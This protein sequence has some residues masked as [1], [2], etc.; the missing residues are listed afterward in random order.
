MNSV[1]QTA[2]RHK[3][4][5]SFKSDNISDKLLKKIIGCGHRSST[6]GNLQSWSVIVTRDTE[7]KQKLYTYHLEQEMILQAPLVLTFCCDHSRTW[8]WLKE[9]SAAKS[10][11][12]L[13]GFMKGAFDALIAA[14]T[15]S[16]AA[17]SEGLGICYMGTTLWAADK[18]TEL[19]ELPK[20]VIPVTSLVMG[21]P[22]ENPIQ[23]DRLP[24]E[25]I[26]HNEKY[27]PW[28]PSKIQ[29][30][31]QEKDQAG[32]KRYMSLPG[33]AEKIER[34]KI[35]NLAQYYTSELKYGKTRH[36]EVSKMYLSLLQSQGLW[37]NE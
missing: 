9:N 7:K 25:A 16:L 6:S 14:Q 19:L 21:Y 15:I 17:E 29:E 8:T 23:R 18:I 28:T 35:G 12:D 5:R 34:F 11:D 10:F 32:W 22:N 2:L 30:L 33:N 26:M 37:N 3:S 31:Y 27:Q 4:I 13:L 1:H 24:L 36:L 20:G